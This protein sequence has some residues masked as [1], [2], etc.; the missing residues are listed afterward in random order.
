MFK[1]PR[2]N[3]TSAVAKLIYDDSSVTDEAHKVNTVSNHILLT[4]FLR[5]DCWVDLQAYCSHIPPE[6]GQ[7]VKEG[8]NVNDKHYNISLTCGGDLKILRGL[9]G[10]CGCSSKFPC[11]YCLGEDGN[12]L[13]MSLQQWLAAGIGMRDIDELELMTHT[14]MDSTRPSPKCKNK[15]VSATSKELG[16]ED[17]GTARRRALQQDH[18]GMCRGR[19]PYIKLVSILD[20]IVDILH[21]MLRVVPQIF[22]H[23]ISKHCDQDKLIKLVEWMEEKF[24]VKLSR[25]KLG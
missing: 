23:T 25:N 5:D 9:L 21:L 12:E 8:I 18:F 4:F 24:K 16:D 13:A 15:Q 20:Y 7:L 17:M 14:V 22:E 3:G 1:N 6:L 19:K 2:T 10:H 11:I